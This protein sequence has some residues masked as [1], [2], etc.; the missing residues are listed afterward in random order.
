M[1]KN[2]EDGTK[3][4]EQILPFFTPDWTVTARMI[5]EMNVVVDIPV[6]LNNVIMND[7]Y[8]GDFRTRRT[9]VWTLDFTL[10]GYVFGPI[11]NSAIIKFANTNFYVATS[12]DI[13]NDVNN[14]APAAANQTRPGLT[15]DGLPTSNAALSIPASEILATDDFGYIEE[16]TEN[17]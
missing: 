16:L 9:L 13:A 15:V 11:K 7:I 6:I 17:P 1:V 14:I 3:I 2:A 12:D 8:D 4:I 10:K 5:P